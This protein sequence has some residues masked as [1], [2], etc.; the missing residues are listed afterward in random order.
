MKLS[1]KW[2]EYLTDQPESGM[3]HQKVTI[4]LK[5]GT[6]HKATIINCSAVMSV[7]GNIGKYPFSEDQIDS[8]AV[9]QK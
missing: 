1:N 2:I 8:I 9:D 6:E 7:D 5:D 4:T 3:G